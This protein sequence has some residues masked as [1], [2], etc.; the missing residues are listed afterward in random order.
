MLTSAISQ[1][2]QL[3]F[4]VDGFWSAV[5]GGIVVS[6]ATMVIDLLLPE[7]R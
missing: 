2:L 7:P 6:I 4:H 5:L 3:G 1:E